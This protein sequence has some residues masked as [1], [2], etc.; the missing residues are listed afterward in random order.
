MDVHILFVGISFFLNIVLI[1][2][3]LTSLAVIIWEL[4]FI[5]YCFEGVSLIANLLQK[6]DWKSIVHLVVCVVMYIT[7]YHFP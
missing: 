6:K 2:M 7:I 1:K 5:G 3:I 4:N